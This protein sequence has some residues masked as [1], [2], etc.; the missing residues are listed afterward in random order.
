VWGDRKPGEED[1]VPAVC[2]AGNTGYFLRTTW[3]NGGANCSS[4]PRHALTVQFCQPYMRPLANLV[5]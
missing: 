4:K 3:H 2:P 5:L 1:A